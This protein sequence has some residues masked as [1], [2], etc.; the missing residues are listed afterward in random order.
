[1]SY[2]LWSLGLIQVEEDI[3][4]KAV[5]ATEYPCLDTRYDLRTLQTPLGPISC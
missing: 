3:L 5:F 4:Y 2:F 1:M